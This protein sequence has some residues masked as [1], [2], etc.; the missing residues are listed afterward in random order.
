MYY[1][2]IV[3]HDEGSAYGVSFPDVPDCFAA[4]DEAEELMANA[5]A[6]LDDYF[7]EGSEAPAPRP[8]EAVRKQ[9]ADDLANGA[10]LMQVPLIQRSTKVVRANISIERGLLE[11]IDAAAERTGL[12]RSA[13]LAHA[14]RREIGFAAGE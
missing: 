10:Y 9:Y 2:A 8:L 4:A 12:N 14:A 1:W 6:A 13:F 5:I 11:A 3:H 7:A